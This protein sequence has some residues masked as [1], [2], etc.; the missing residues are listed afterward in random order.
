MPESSN[1]K[2]NWRH[3]AVI[4]GVCL[5]I[6]G[7][8]LSWRSFASSE[9][10]RVVPAWE[11]M[12]P[13]H[14]GGWWHVTMF[15]Q[16]YLRKP[17]GMPWAIAAMSSLLGQTEA[18]ARSVSAIATALAALAAWWFA[19]R[20]FGSRLG[21]VAGLAFATMPQLWSP[22]RSAEIEAL[23][24]FGV[25][26]A[27]LA[28]VDLA[29]CGPR[30]RGSSKPDTPDGPSTPTLSGGTGEGVA[31][32]IMP[33]ASGTP[34]LRRSP[35]GD[36]LVVALGAAGLIVAALAKGPAGVP[37]IGGVILAAGLMRMWTARGLAGLGVMALVA[38]GVLVPLGRRILAANADPSA[39][40]Q[41]SEAF[42]WSK[43]VAPVLMLAPMA[44]FSALPASLA[45][46]FPW[47]KDADAE[48]GCDPAARRSLLIA[49]VLGASWLA[50]LAVYMALGVPNPRYAMPAAGLLCPMACYAVR[51]AWGVHATFNPKRRQLVKRLMLGNPAA[52]PVLLT[53]IALLTTVGARSYKIGMDGR[54]A[55]AHLA[56]A[57]V[58]AGEGGGRGGDIWADGLIEARPDVLLYA[59]RVAAKTADVRLRPLWKKFEMAE[60]RLPPRGELIV[61]RIDSEGDERA[62]Y[63]EAIVDGRLVAAGDGEVGRYKFRVYRV[64]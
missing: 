23:N 55:G 32:R 14:P 29:L 12:E 4:V 44:L 3:A 52:V 27:A 8:G 30:R 48:A 42:M 26:L 33:A 35:A 40:T 7:V 53:C 43:G 28:M 36:A 16:T 2:L 51:G 50:S 63:E 22:G 38:A 64:R 62:R 17:P 58:L 60:G 24:N 41:G 54:M 61:L 25:L 1:Q 57:A 37:V 49:R 6:Y 39:I 20:W 10:H 18:V 47:G 45:M 31:G 21:I 46:L 5:V 19:S 56:E 11:M 9:G 13:G 15:G 59:Q 34:S